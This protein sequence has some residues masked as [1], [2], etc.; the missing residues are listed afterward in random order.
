[1]SVQ[2]FRQSLLEQEVVPLEDEFGNPIEDPFTGE[3]LAVIRNTPVLVDQVFVRQRF[4]T[5]VATNWARTRARLQLDVA[6]D[7]YQQGD[8]PETTSSQVL[9]DLRRSL[10]R[11]TSGNLQLR[12]WDWRRD[13][14]GGDIFNNSDFDQYRVSIGLSHRLGRRTSVGLNVERTERNGESDLDS[15]DENRVSAFL[16]MQLR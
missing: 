13:G 3:G 7:E 11:Q 15:Y 1:V 8:N 12:Y 2:D 6:W 14:G 9:F 5:S 4:T 10:T 16:S